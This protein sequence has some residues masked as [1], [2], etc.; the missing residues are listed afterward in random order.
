M[1]RKAIKPKTTRISDWGYQVLYKC[2]KCGYSFD[3]ADD[4]FYYCP[5]CGSKID[6]DVI[7]EVNEEWRSKYISADYDH[8]REL[9]KELDLLNQTITDGEKKC[10][11]YTLATKRAVT[12]SNIGYYLSRGSSKEEL[13]KNGF[14]TE[15]D[16]VEAEL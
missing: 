16:F 15:E 4:G 2:G 5:H 6:W 1:P 11:E 12:K 14:F 10:M 7:C 3:L 9:C 8:R 13:I